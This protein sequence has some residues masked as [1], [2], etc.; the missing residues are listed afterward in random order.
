M[1]V[2]GDGVSRIKGDSRV[3]SISEGTDAVSFV[4]Q[5]T[6]SCLT[7][8]ERQCAVFDGDIFDPCSC[9]AP[10]IGENAAAVVRRSRN[11]YVNT[12]GNKTVD[13]KGGVAIIQGTD[14]S[15]NRS[16]GITCGSF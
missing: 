12:I 16:V 14:Q 15:A 8:W 5:A 7:G 4:D 2:T 10:L 11:G 9:S 6:K 13:F 3:R 1:G